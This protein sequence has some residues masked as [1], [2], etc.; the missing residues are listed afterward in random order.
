M[1]NNTS[2]SSF[3]LVQ[4]V[5]ANR[6]LD[7]KLAMLI[8]T[9]SSHFIERDNMKPCRRFVLLDASTKSHLSHELNVSIDSIKEM[10]LQCEQALLLYKVRDPHYYELADWLVWAYSQKTKR[11]EVISTYTAGIVKV[12]FYDENDDLLYSD[13]FVMEEKNLC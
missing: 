10:I 8:D 7:P 9:L 13:G 4:S 11:S 2:N 6:G 5:L 3:S 1:D 12:F